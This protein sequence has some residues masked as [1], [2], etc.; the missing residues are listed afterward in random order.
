[1]K[2]LNQVASKTAPSHPTL[3]RSGWLGAVVI[4]IAISVPAFAQDSPARGSPPPRR[5]AD[6]DTSFALL[7]TEL[8]QAERALAPLAK[9]LGTTRSRLTA[10]PPE[11]VAPVHSSTVLLSKRLGDRV[12]WQI[13][14]QG[15]ARTLAGIQRVLLEQIGQRRP[16]LSKALATSEKAAAASALLAAKAETDSNTKARLAKRHAE[17]SAIEQRWQ[18]EAAALAAEVP[19]LTAAM[20]SSLRLAK[21]LGA[22]VTISKQELKSALRREALVTEFQGREPSVLVGLLAAK[23]AERGK[24]SAELK[25]K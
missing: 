14:R 18:R 3:R 9:L 7:E 2:P 16:L 15:R 4:G 22:E 24:R 5:A 10:L 6:T 20:E 19:K 17:I 25:T 11:A 8:K 12:S 1:V 23:N 13:S 21:R